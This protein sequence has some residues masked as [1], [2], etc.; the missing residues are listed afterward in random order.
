[1]RAVPGRLA[2]RGWPESRPDV[3]ERFDAVTLRRSAAP[4]PAARR[5]R[6][7]PSDGQSA[8]GSTPGQRDP[9]ARRG[10]AA[11]CFRRAGPP[12][13]S[14]VRLFPRREQKYAKREHT[15]SVQVCRRH[16]GLR[17]GCPRRRA[18]AA[19]TPAPRLVLPRPWTAAPGGATLP[20]LAVPRRPEVS[21]PWRVF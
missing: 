11:G 7:R 14:L 12:G 1:M 4:V 10:P 17:T 13:P 19:R 2:R 16:E 3:L 6:R 20:H 15:S 8:E 5:R 18:R 9:A 21:S